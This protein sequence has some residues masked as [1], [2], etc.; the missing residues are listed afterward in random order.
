MPQPF[1]ERHM[2]LVGVF[3]IPGNLP[4]SENGVVVD[5]GEHLLNRFL[6]RRLARI[7]IGVEHLDVGASAVVVALQDARGGDA[8]PFDDL[9]HVQPAIVD[10]GRILN[11]AG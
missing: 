11:V 9:V 10:D 8:E 4:R 6:Y 7:E 1:F 2:G 3:E 5:T